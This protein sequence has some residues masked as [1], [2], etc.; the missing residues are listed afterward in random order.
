MIELF[1]RISI[2]VYYNNTFKVK[3]NYHGTMMDAMPEAFGDG[4]NFKHSKLHGLVRHLVEDRKVSFEEIK[5][6]ANEKGYSGCSYGNEKNHNFYAG[7]FWTPIFMA[8]G[9]FI[10]EKIGRALGVEGLGRA[11]LDFLGGLSGLTLAV[12]GASNMSIDENE[13]FYHFLR[14]EYKQ[15]LKEYDRTFKTS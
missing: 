7:V 5:S 9:I 2:I 12:A 15:E 1:L 10:A 6:F 3:L 8:G 14:R 11:G 4:S 13:E